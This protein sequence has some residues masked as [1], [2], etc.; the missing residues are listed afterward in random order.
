MLMSL[1]CGC[2]TAPHLRSEEATITARESYERDHINLEFIVGLP[3]APSTFFIPRPGNGISHFGQDLGAEARYR[4]GR[5][6]A[7]GARFI[8]SSLPGATWQRIE[9]NSFSLAQ[10]LMGMSYEPP[11]DVICSRF[12]FRAGYGEAIL[13]SRTF[14]ELAAGEGWGGELAAEISTFTGTPVFKRIL[15]AF[16]W[17]I[18]PHWFSIEA[19][20]RYALMPLKFSV[21]VDANGDGLVD[22]RKGSDYVD[23]RARKV[24]N[25]SGLFMRIGEHWSF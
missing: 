14:D 2:A 11:G 23:A 25:W 20:Y 8:G 16:L 17:A 5:T 15:P 4:L 1:T 18:F 3:V 10:G 12:S 13:Y 22:N 9:N 24:R 19:G 7:V 21:D 6:W